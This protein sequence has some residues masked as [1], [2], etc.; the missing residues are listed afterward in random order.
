M[1]IIVGK[2]VTCELLGS[3]PGELHYEVTVPLQEKIAKLSK[4]IRGLDGHSG[5]S[6]EGEIKKCKT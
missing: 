4:M 2:N 5:T 1:I 6:V 3:A